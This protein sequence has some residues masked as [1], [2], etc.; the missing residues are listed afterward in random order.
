MPKIVT[1]TPNLPANPGDTYVEGLKSVAEQRDISVDEA[2]DQ[3]VEEME[4]NQQEEHIQPTRD[5]AEYIKSTS[6]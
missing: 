2:A 1:E 3:L 5:A 6:S 4:Q